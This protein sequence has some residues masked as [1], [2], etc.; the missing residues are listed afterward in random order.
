M[1]SKLALENSEDS[2]I[3]GI[4][5]KVANKHNSDIVNKM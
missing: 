5:I 2:E 1:L 3:Y 4:P